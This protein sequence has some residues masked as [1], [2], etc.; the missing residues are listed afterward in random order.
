LLGDPSKAKS[1]L[2]WAPRI[3][4]DELVTEMVREDLKSA[5]RDELIKNHGFTAMDYHE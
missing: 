2:G 4:F 5:K 3:S 1:K